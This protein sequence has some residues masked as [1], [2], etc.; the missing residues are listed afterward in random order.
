MHP[1]HGDIRAAAGTP[2]FSHMPHTRLAVLNIV[3]LSESLLG[4][5]LP[6]L[7]PSPKN[8][9]ANRTRRHFPR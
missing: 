8:T 7:T 4:P 3:G 6:G 9:A 2:P 1:P 5:H